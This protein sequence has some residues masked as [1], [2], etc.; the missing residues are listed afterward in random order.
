MGIDEL[1][2]PTEEEQALEMLKKRVKEVDAQSYE[3]AEQIKQYKPDFHLVYKM[4]VHFKLSRALYKI[5]ARVD[6]IFAENEKLIQEN[7]AYASDKAEEFDFNYSLATGMRKKT[8]KKNLPSK[9]PS[10]LHLLSDS[11]DETGI[12]PFRVKEYIETNLAAI[13]YQ[14]KVLGSIV[15]SLENGK[16]TAKVDE[17]A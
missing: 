6:E 10:L 15:K 13:R 17:V 3:L 11:M 12:N 5:K 1:L 14:S 4:R 2:K 8:A 9:A 7:R 16:E